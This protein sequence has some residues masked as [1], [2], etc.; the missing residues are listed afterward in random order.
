MLCLLQSSLSLNSTQAFVRTNISDPLLCLTSSITLR[1]KPLPE[2]P[3]RKRLTELIR[4]AGRLPSLTDEPLEDDLDSGRN[5]PVIG[6]GI[7]SYLEE[8]NL[9]DGLEI[10]ESNMTSLP[11]INV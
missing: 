2:T 10:R 9:L 3:Q 8:V 4:A 6:G 11:Y 5:S 7:E 1:D